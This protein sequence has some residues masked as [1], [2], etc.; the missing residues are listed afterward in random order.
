[1]QDDRVHCGACGGDVIPEA[2]SLA[3]KVANV[4]V[5]IGCFAVGPWCS[6]LLPL[7]IVLIPTFLFGAASAISYTSRRAFFD[8][9]CPRCGKPLV[10]CARA[11]ENRAEGVLA[12]LR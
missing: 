4:A 10:G 12:D 1:M 6:L 9:R 5:W 8:P 7:N 11:E 3:W 2:P